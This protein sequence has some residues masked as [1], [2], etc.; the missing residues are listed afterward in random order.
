MASP[1]TMLPDWDEIS[2]LDEILTIF[3]PSAHGTQT[4]S[5]LTI[6]G[7]ATGVEP[8]LITVGFPPFSHNL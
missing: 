3:R 4:T 1:L 2:V 7:E 6:V 5:P 8:K